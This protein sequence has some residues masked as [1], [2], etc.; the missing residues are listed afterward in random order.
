MGLGWYSAALEYSFFIL[1]HHPFKIDHYRV[2]RHIY[3]LALCIISLFHV[4]YINIQISSLSSLVIPPLSWADTMAA[5]SVGHRIP[6][7]AR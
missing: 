7:C 6:W 2:P 4:K 3:G 1:I 5:N